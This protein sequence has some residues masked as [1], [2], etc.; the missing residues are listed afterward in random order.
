[1]QKAQAVHEHQPQWANGAL[2][3]HQSSQRSLSHTPFTGR[4]DVVKLRTNRV[5]LACMCLWVH[6]LILVFPSF[7][8]PESA[9]NRHGT[10]PKAHSGSR[11]STARLTR[12][13]A[14]TMAQA[15]TLERIQASNQASL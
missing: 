6:E 13:H 12:A 9:C 11:P 7:A 15:A 3:E 10:K 2:D 8:F 14:R 4:V 1:V 5:R